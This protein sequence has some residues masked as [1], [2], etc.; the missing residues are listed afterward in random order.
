[1]AA[2]LGERYSLPGLGL[3]HPWRRLT[4]ARLLDA[5]RTA[6]FTRGTKSGRRLEFEKVEL[7]AARHLVRRSSRRTRG[8]AETRRVEPNRLEARRSVYLLACRPAVC[9][10]A[11][12]EGRNRV[13]PRGYTSENGTRL[14]Q[15]ITPIASYSGTR[16]IAPPNRRTRE[17][18]KDG[19]D[20]GHEDDSQ[21]PDQAL[22][23]TQTLGSRQHDQ[24]RNRQ[25]DYGDSEHH[26]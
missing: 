16:I 5:E 22:D 4:P 9:F 26:S 3:W 8:G 12:P 6:H 2:R 18:P 25:C 20:Y 15:V 21:R 1:M 11:E 24:G 10:P 14:L 13:P 7:R 19:S 17:Q 23:A